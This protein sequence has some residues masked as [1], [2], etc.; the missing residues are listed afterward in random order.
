MRSKSSEIPQDS[1]LLKHIL[2]FSQTLR[3]KKVGVTTENVVDALRGISF[4]DIQ[5]KDDFYQLL[6]SNFVSKREESVLFDELFEHFW[7][8]KKGALPS[9]KQGGKEETGGSRGKGQKDSLDLSTGDPSFLESSNSEEQMEGEPERREVFRYSPEEVLSRKEFGHLETE[10]LE[11]V[12][13]FVLILTRRLALKLSRRWKKGKGKQ[14]DLRR[15]VR[16]SVKYGGEMMELRRKKRKQKPLRIVLI[17]DISGSMDIYIQAFLLFMYGFQHYYPQCETFV[18]STRLS[19]TTSLLKRRDFREALHL[20][21]HKVLD[22]SGGTNIGASFHQLH[23]HHKDIFSPHRTV[24]LVFSDG[25]DRG[26]DT[27]L[28]DSE[29]RYLKKQAKKIIWLN[30]L[31]GS[32]SY[33]PLCKGMSTVLPYLDHFLPCHNFLSMRNLSHLIMKI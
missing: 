27:S 17:C 10:E 24:L 30:P 26:E 21:S 20:L 2:L 19:H 16:Q 14:I 18:F 29:M 7:S 3:T 13:E 6:K 15:S 9:V 33:Q 31:A 23:K 22:W 8:L 32:Q 5:S 11:K 28:L 1:D 4:I 25:W 12:K